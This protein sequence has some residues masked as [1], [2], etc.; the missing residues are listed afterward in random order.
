[1]ARIREVPKLNIIKFHYN[2]DRN[3]F[4]KF[5]SNMAADYLNSDKMS[6]Y[7]TRFL[8]IMENFL[9]IPRF[10]WINKSRCDMLCR[11]TTESATTHRKEE[12]YS[13]SMVILSPVPR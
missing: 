9:K 3:K 11:S 7:H 5:L 6:E 1:M 13:E 8:L 10:R 4:D 12:F 2:G